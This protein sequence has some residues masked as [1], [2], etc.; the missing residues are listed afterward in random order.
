MKRILFGVVALVCSG[1]LATAG[2]APPAAGQK[3]RERFVP[4][5]AGEKG[6]WG[7][8]MSICPRES[9]GPERASLR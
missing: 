5:K 8:G 7:R 3:I 4:D 1:F 9:M 2:D 6:A